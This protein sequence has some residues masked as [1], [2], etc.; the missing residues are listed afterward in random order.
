[1]ECLA[2]SALLLAAGEFRPRLMVA[3][4]DP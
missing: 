2:T 3:P 4:A 1:V